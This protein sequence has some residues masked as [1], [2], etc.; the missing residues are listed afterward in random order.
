MTCRLS[1]VVALLAVTLGATASVADGFAGRNGPLVYGWSE[2]DEPE[3][4]PSWRYAERIR[5]IPPGG[6]D[7]PLTVTGCEQTLAAQAPPVERTC[8]AQTF[9][10]PAVSRDRRQIAFDNGASLALVNPDGSNRR[11]LP[12]TSRD[13][14]E[15]AFSAAGGRRPDRVLGRL[16]FHRLRRRR[17]IDLDPRLRPRDDATGDSRGRRPRVVLAQLDRVRQP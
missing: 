16:P 7:Q 15:P 13:D 11:V 6:R 14:G 5:L 4:G 8:A 17:S 1:A 12:A 3:T 9:A 10:D 2:A